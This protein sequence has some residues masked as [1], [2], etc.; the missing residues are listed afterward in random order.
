M[1]CLVRTCYRQKLCDNKAYN[2][3]VLEMY[4]MFFRS[5]Y[6]FH[7]IAWGLLETLIRLLLILIYC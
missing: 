2:T 6:Y 4:Y 1:F 7:K 3:I 5:H